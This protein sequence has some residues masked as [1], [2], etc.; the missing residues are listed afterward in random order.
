MDQSIVT[1][2]L[3]ALIQ[4]ATNPQ[5]RTPD[6]AA[7][8]AVCGL[9]NREPDCS[10]TAA[11]LIISKVQSLQ[12]AES[13]Q[14]L[15]I[16]DMCMEHCGN[17]FR[18]EVGKFKFL[19]ELIKLVSPKYYGFMTPS[20][21]QAEVLSM[22]ESWVHHY[23]KETKIKEAYEMLRKQGVI[24]EEAVA[25]HDTDNRNGQNSS[26]H[27]VEICKSSILEDN[28]KSRLLQKLLQSKNPED[29]QAANRLIKTMV[30][31]EE[32]RVEMNCKRVIELEGMFNNAKLL[33]EMLDSYSPGESTEQDLE[34][35]KELHSNCLKF[36]STVF[37]LAADV[38]DNKALYNEVLTANDALGDVFDKYAVK[39]L[40]RPV[41]RY[42][43]QPSVH[44]SPESNLTS[45]L[46]SDSQMKAAEM[47]QL[48][49]L[50]L[51]SPV[52]EKSLSDTA[53][54]LPEQKTD[55]SLSKAAGGTANDLELLCDI[56]GAA[57]DSKAPA[58]LDNAVNSVLCNMAVTD[59]KKVMSSSTEKASKSKGLDELDILG[60]TL[61]RQSLTANSKMSP[62]F[63]LSGSNEG[64]E[65]QQSSTQK[66]KIETH[67]T[68]QVSKTVRTS[69][70]SLDVDLLTD[71]TNLV[72][73]NA[74]GKDYFVKT[75]PNCPNGDEKKTVSA[76]E[77]LLQSNTNE[78]LDPESSVRRNSILPDVK[79][80]SDISVSLENIKPGPK[81]PITILNEVN[82]I[83]VVIHL[84]LNAPRPD[85]SVFVVT[86]TSKNENSLSNYLF[87]PVVPKDFRLRLQPASSSELPAYSPF[88]SPPVITQVMLIASPRKDPIVFQFVLSY[89]MDGET[90]T[91]MGKIQDFP[92]S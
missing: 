23:P 14:A 18:A 75:S 82:G 32:R 35:I 39:I 22:L 83:T 34:L 76:T 29:L 31:E 12:E 30:K 26:Q 1:T 27:H 43:S 50:D 53:A 5:N 21:V 33:S 60:E 19:N 24:K 89:T 78:P 42:A 6:R 44:P 38:K 28:E 40:G 65:H 56:F 49:L 77:N 2:S 91:E 51:S 20:S 55:G 45:K 70:D 90:I 87:Q 63:N 58:L 25:V 3:E 67:S 74:I 61:L 13:L 10:G 72:D 64:T 59:N 17:S 47:Q 81:S 11:K 85:V 79:P 86:T 8:E 80:L 41:G 71:M 68:S 52:E 15:S 46:Q 66:P 92:L 37:K 48:S 73:E 16:L 54:F 88:L 36:R 4:R 69:I 57:A 62:Q 84:A 7:I 9:I